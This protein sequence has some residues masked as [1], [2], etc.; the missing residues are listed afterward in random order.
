VTFC[1]KKSNFSQKNVIWISQNAVWP[2]PEHVQPVLWPTLE[3]HQRGCRWHH[4]IQPL[5]WGEAQGSGSFGE[6]PRAGAGIRRCNRFSYFVPRSPNQLKW[7]FPSIHVVFVLNFCVL[8]DT[9]SNKFYFRRRLFVFA[10]VPLLGVLL[11]KF[12]IGQSCGNFAQL[13]LTS[14]ITI[15]WGQYKFFTPATATLQNKVEHSECW[16]EVPLFL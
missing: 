14:R 15:L 12:L 13:C 6:W 9:K 5:H 1:E 11:D 2:P 4:H 10:S 8:R 16:V 3:V 7:H